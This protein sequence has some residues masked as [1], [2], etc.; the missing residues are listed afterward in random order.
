MRFA[1]FKKY[2]LLFDGLLACVLI[3]L[4]EAISRHSLIFAF[5]FF[6]GTPLTFLYNA[7]LIFTTLLIIYLFKRRMFVRVILSVFW[8]ILG[9]INGVVLSNRVTPFNFTDLKL[10]GDLFA[11]DNS[12]YLSTAEEAV[13]IIALVCLTVLLILLA[14]RGPKYQGYVHRLRNAVCLAALIFALPWITKAAIHM[15][16]LTDYYGNLAE[17]YQ[18]YGF[19]YSFVASAVD[20]GMSEP[21]NYS[22]ETITAINDSVVVEETSAEADELPNIVVVQLETFIDPYEL[23]FLEYSEDPI[24]NFHKL[25]EN[26]TSGYLTVPVVGAGTANTEFEVLT[27][28]G[29][30]FFGLGEYPYKT[31]LKETVCESIASDLAQIGYGTHAVHNNGGNFYSRAT[32]FSQMGFDSYT[33]EE[34]M[35]IT[36]YNEYGTWPTDDILVGETEKALDSTED[37]LDFVFTITVQSH[38]SYPTERILEDPEIEVTGGETEGEHYQWE[39][40]I[41]ELHEVDMFIGNLIEML[42]NRD[43]KTIVI[44]YG[45]HLPTMGLTDEDMNNGSIY[46]TTY[47]TWNNFGLE[48]EDADLAAY[49]LMAYITDQLDIHEGT[50]FTY[51]QSAME[52]GTTGEESYVTDWELL[53]YDLL[54]GELYSYGGEQIYEA[55]NLVM[56][57]EDVLIESV[58]ISDDGEELVIDGE[59]FTPSSVVYINNEAVETEYISESELHVFLS[60]APKGELSVVVSQVGSKNTVFRSSNEMIAGV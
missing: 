17:G 28:M 45:D 50:M 55:S 33:S 31:I 12:R 24:P 10:V 21:D 2:S 25:M 44:L 27:G 51:H 29:I 18:R 37:Q 6:T 38:G 60:G 7:L 41:N 52:A 22:E 58:R 19:V 32:I 59:N 16:V 49:Q 4:I 39:Y 56:G 11:M 40:Y 48:E 3:L 42:E 36:E 8:L 20:T 23:N 46:Q 47:V 26:Y 30:Q 5:W 53:Q 54:Y 9:I 1:V 43:E 15:N 35:N 13:I 34:L 57:V 14:V